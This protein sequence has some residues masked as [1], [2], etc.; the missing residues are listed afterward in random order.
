MKKKLVSLL[1]AVVLVGSMASMSAAGAGLDNFQKVNTYTAGQFTDVSGWYAQNVQTAYE[2]GLVRGDSDTTFSPNGK[3]S[4][5]ETLALASRLHSIYNTGSANFVQGAPW[6]AV[7]VD[8]AVDNGIIKQGEFSDYNVSA[9]RSQFAAILAKAFPA[10]ALEAMNTVDD[11]MIPDVQEGAENYDSIYMLYR[12]GIL[13]GNDALGTFAPQ[14][15]IMRSEVATIVTRMAVPALR[16]S[17]TLKAVPATGVVLSS[18]ELTLA[19]GAT[20]TLTASLTPA[21]ATPQAM[22]WKS[23]N[24]SVATVNSGVVT[25]VAA[26]SATITCETAKG[27]SARCTVTVTPAPVEVTGVSLNQTKIELQ[28][29]DTYQLKAT[30]QP[31]NATDKTVTWTASNGTASV[32]STGVVTANREGYCLITATT[33][34]GQTASCS[35]HITKATVKIILRDSLPIPL[36]EYDYN[37]RIESSWRVND[38]R[39]EI[40]ENYDGLYTVEMYFSGE[41]TYDAR[42]SGQGAT[43][44]I[45]WQLFDTEGYV[46]DSGTV[47]SPSVREGEKFRDAKD[48]IFDLA[49]GTY[50]LELSSTN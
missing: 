32:S 23:S 12:G 37:D 48:Y 7:Y 44:K 8:Y 29:G 17:L 36:N 41:K 18:T 40:E 45:S 49:G 24:T 5:A 43:C 26:G 25:G 2:L 28:A 10:E 39:V 16:Q 4:I 20:Q 30:I 6:Y 38:F 14:S 50:Y 9:T 31:S 22:T 46:V 42:G 13:T 35:V 3:I 27:L 15:N 47:Y 19:A 11:G 34:N 33:A 21:D 1:L